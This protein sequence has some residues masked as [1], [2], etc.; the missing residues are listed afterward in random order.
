MCQTLVIKDEN[1]P[2]GSL[3][4]K[5][6]ISI[7]ELLIPM[8]N[9]VKHVMKTKISASSAYHAVMCKYDNQTRV[10]MSVMT[11]GVTR[12]HLSV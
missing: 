1:D 5:G 2:P 7:F 4:P 12:V 3:G 11:R 6:A 9:Q 10:L 8:N